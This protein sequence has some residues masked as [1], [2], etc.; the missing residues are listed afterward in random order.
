MTCRLW[1]GWATPD[2]AD[3]YEALIRSTIFPG[4]LGCG[5]ADLEGI[6]LLRRLR[7]AEVEFVTTLLRVLKRGEGFRRTGLG[8]VGGA[9]RRTRRVRPLRRQRRSTTRCASK[10]DATLRSRQRRG[11]KPPA[12]RCSPPVLNPRDQALLVM[13]SSAMLRGTGS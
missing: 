6:E 9:A 13:I 1:D 10:A 3:G 8:G 11:R 12:P 4:I 7:G 2:Y 5:I